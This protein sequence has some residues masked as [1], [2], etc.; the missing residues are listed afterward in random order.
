LSNALPVPQPGPHFSLR[1]VDEPRGSDPQLVVSGE[2]DVPYIAE[3]DD[4]IGRIG[5]QDR[6]RGVI[7][8]VS[9]VT[10]LAACGVSRLV[11]AQHR[12]GSVGQ[13]LAL[14]GTTGFQRRLLALGSFDCA[15][16]ASAGQ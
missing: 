13:T 3:L 11:A 9:Q 4:A 6:S 5:R 12:L 15:A 2:I 1:V 10:F 7:V 16:T 8:D 14:H